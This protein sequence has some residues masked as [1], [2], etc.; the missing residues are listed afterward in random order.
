MVFVM[1]S[2]TKTNSMTS[3]SPEVQRMHDIL[4]QQKVAY[5]RYPVP[6]AKERIE[7]LARL[8]ESSRKIPRSIWQKQSIKTMGIV[9]SAKLKLVNYSHV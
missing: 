7:R 9:R 6:T 8:K 5:Q 3:Y 4:E 1:N 2:H